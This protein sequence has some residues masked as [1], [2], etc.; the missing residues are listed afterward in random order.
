[1]TWASVFDPRAMVKAP[2]IGQRSSR[3]FSFTPGRRPRLPF[4]GHRGRRPGVKL[5]V[6]EE[7]WPIA[8]AFTIARGSKTEAHVIVVELTDGAARGRGEAVP[9]ARYGE[10][11]EGAI[12]AIEALRPALEGGLDRIGLQ[13]A[14]KASAARNALDCALWDLEAK[15]SGV[16]AWAAAGRPRLDP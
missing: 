6:R 11:V 7:R 9:Y 5:N 1:M 15:R 2:A 16:R 4:D 13:S 8:G 12:G 3:T 14:M 10:T